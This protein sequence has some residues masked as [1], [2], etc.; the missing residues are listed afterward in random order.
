MASEEYFIKRSDVEKLIEKRIALLEENAA[1]GKGFKN[2][3]INLSALKLELSN[4]YSI[5]IKYKGG[6]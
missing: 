3:L 1:P 4:L 2:A 6:Q 5:K